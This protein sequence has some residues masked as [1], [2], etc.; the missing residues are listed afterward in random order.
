VL[1]LT[2]EKPVASPASCRRSIVLFPAVV[3][4]VL[5][6]GCSDGEDEGSEDGSTSP[7][8]TT[9][10]SH[11][12]RDPS[13]S[14]PVSKSPT[15][16]GS[17]PEDP[18]RA[19]A[20]IRKTWRKFFDPSTPVDERVGLV[21]DGEQ[22]ELMIHPLFTDRRAEKLR[23]TTTTVTFKGSRE[24]E[25]AYQLTLDGQPLQDGTPGEAVFQDKRWKVALQTVCTLTTHGEDVPRAANCAQP[26]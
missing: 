2:E 21:E 7:A 14:P 23:A 20:E 17:A 22:N 12:P 8:P 5:V 15:V 9:S 11:A 6:G 19:E 25:V 1:R 16:T 13:T 24:A 10:S 26:Q 4:L 3:A 18:V